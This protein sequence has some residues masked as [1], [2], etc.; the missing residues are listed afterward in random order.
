MQRLSRQCDVDCNLPS[1]PAHPVTQE[2]THQ[3]A[4]PTKHACLERDH[5]LPVQ[6]SQLGHSWQAADSPP[7][8]SGGSNHKHGKLAC[9]K[10]DHAFAVQAAQLGAS[11]HPCQ[12]HIAHEQLTNKAA[13]LE[14]DHAL[15][16]QVAQSPQHP[17]ARLQVVV[18]NQGLQQSER[19]RR[20]GSEYF[21]I[22]TAK[23]C[24]SFC[25]SKTATHGRPR[26]RVSAVQ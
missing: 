15:P 23:R 10:R 24:V 7:K 3:P 21:Q 2:V 5:A 16:V 25:R 19:G 9:L 22:K 6:V 4:E 14:R 8:Q 26:A 1:Q 13:C 17:L 18:E 11:T 20:R 12:H